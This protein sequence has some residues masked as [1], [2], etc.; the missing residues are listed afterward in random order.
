MSYRKIKIISDYTHCLH[1]YGLLVHIVCVKF[2]SLCIYYAVCSI[3]LVN[4]Y[5]PPKFFDISNFHVKNILMAKNCCMRQ[6]NS[7][8]RHGVMKLPI[9][10]FLELII[11][12]NIL[13]R[14]H[15]IKLNPLINIFLISISGISC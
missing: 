13:K 7:I 11:R 2:A 4:A 10:L 1:K 8:Y 14:S 3:G 12:R 6:L 9:L 5:N 15:F